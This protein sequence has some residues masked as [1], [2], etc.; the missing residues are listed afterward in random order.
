MKKNEGIFSY[1]ELNKLQD[2]C[3]KC[4]KEDKAIHEKRKYN[5]SYAPKEQ[6]QE[7]AQQKKF[8]SNQGSN[9]GTKDTNYKNKLKY[10]QSSGNIFIKHSF[11]KNVDDKD[12]EIILNHKPNINNPNNVS[13]IKSDAFKN[14]VNMFE[15]KK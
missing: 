11:L 1:Q 6:K 7:L 14:R 8:P 15:P 3:N 10:S 12:I 4:A 9:K 13:K 5:P 2:F